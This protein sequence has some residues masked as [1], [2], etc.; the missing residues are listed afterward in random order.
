[1]AIVRARMVRVEAIVARRVSRRL[2]ERTQ[3]VDEMSVLFCSR[4]DASFPRQ[5]WRMD[6]QKRMRKYNEQASKSLG[7]KSR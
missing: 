7:P 3:I 2:V 1:M 6:E 4:V 5:A